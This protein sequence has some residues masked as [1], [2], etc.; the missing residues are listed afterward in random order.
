M[1]GKK[2]PTVTNGLQTIL[3]L[4]TVSSAGRKFRVRVTVGLHR[5]RVRFLK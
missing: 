5:V 2:P 4:S 1:N 3:A